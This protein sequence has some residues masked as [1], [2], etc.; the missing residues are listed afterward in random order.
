MGDC[1]ITMKCMQVVF[2]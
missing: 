2:C 1:I